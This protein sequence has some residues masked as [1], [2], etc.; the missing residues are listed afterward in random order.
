[1]IVFSTRM[2]LHV[3]TICTGHLQEILLPLT[4]E[5]FFS[6]SSCYRPFS[7]PKTNYHI[8][9]SINRCLLYLVT[10]SS[11]VFLFSYDDRPSRS[12][13]KDSISQDF[14]TT[15][16]V[17]VPFRSTR[18]EIL[19]LAL[20]LKNNSA[21]QL[22]ENPSTIEIFT[23]PSCCFIDD[24]SFTFSCNETLNLNKRNRPFNQRSRSWINLTIHFF[25]VFT[26]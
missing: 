23:S 9:F 19:V 5:R 17:F 10:H 7:Y 2:F 24:W 26:D 4:A 18:I 22:Y 8:C 1:M 25:G 20:A 13:W 15:C 11:I 16:S 21:S 3:S 6:R 14:I 12:I